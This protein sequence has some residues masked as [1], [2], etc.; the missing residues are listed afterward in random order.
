MIKSMTGFATASATSGSWSLSVEIRAY[1]SRQL[2][3]ALRLSPGYSGLEERA[4][5]VI[6]ARLTRGRVEARIQIEDTAAACGCVEADLTRARAVRSALEQV[7][8][9][10]GLPDPVTLEMVL[11]AGS[12]LKTIQPE[13]DLEAAEALLEAV[14]IQALEHLDGMRT[15]EGYALSSD[16]SQRLAT[17]E[18]ALVEITRQ[19]EGLPAVYQERLK[20]RLASLTHGWIEIDS[21]RIAQEAALLAD[22]CDISEEIVRARSHLEQ[23][24]R[25]MDAA[26]AGGRKLNFLLQELNREF[27][28]MGSKIG[29]A[30]AAHEIVA[31]KTELEKMR[32]QIQNVE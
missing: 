2:D 10:L 30:A 19:A 11:A 32:E 20:E 31:V 14:L 8:A 24:R 12:L 18:A 28:T 9:E 23:F 21:V 1:N 15:A 29:N 27:N 22:R 13:V 7:R 3:L 16:L 4:R 25:I 26:E 6:A 17:I 5:A